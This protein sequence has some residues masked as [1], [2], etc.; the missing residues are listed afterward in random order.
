[1]KTNYSSTPEL[2]LLK[3]QSNKRKNLTK[4]FGERLTRNY[5]SE[6]LYF[7]SVVNPAPSFY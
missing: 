3:E 5:A 7:L 4:T 1:M 6:K 2:E